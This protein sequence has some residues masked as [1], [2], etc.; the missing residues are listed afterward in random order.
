[1]DAS[2]VAN[3]AIDWFRTQFGPVCHCWA[4][5]ADCSDA[6]SQEEASKVLFETKPISCIHANGINKVQIR[7]ACICVGNKQI[8]MRDIWCE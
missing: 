8:A 1:M 3:L 6:K 7:T 5:C 4:D 2:G